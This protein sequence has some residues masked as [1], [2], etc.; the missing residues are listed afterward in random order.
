M[1]AITDSE[2]L[3]LYAGEA[4][5]PAFEELV[6]RHLNHV[7]SAAMRRVNGDRA[8]AEDVT[9][10]VFVDFARKASRIPADM[11]P[12]GWLHRHTGFVASKMID[13]ER[14][15]RSREQE[16]ATMNATELSTA[17]APE[18]SATSPLLDAAMDTLPSS[19]RDAI[20]LR[21]FEDRDFRS[22]GEALGMS[23]DSAQKKVSRAMDKL[24]AASYFGWQTN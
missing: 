9:Q 22:V 1:T 12:G 13:K 8:L 6:R 23:D 2:L 3:G 14:R 21:F 16:A 4:S 7:F 19:D 15:R 17:N 18:W 10:T 24:R 11:P 20:V 5:A